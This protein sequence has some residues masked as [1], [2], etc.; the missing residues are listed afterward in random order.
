MKVPSS[1]HRVARRAASGIGA[2]LV[3][4]AGI[5]LSPA[6]NHAASA[7][8]STGVYHPVTPYRILDTR[9]TGG[10]LSAGETRTVQVTGLP[11]EAVP[12]NA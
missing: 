8:A 4:F 3:A 6:V 1:V 2:A 9:E 11:D 12:A 10:P 7:A 5:G